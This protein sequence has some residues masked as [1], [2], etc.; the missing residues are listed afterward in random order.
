VATMPMG[1]MTHR[2]TFTPVDGGTEITQTGSLDPNL[3]GRL[4]SPLVR[5]MLRRRFRLIAGELSGYV[6]TSSSREATM[7]TSGASAT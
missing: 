3:L 2:F 1:R 7:P 4:L 5:V 6:G